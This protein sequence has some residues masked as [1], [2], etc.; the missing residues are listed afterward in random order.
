MS[1]P[2]MSA[3]SS[4]GVHGLLVECKPSRRV[5]LE[6]LATAACRAFSYKAAVG[7]D[8]LGGKISP[9]GPTGAV[10][11]EFCGYD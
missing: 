5:V 1:R 11:V 2:A 8:W 10:G 7:I 4:S 6:D 3:F 9:A